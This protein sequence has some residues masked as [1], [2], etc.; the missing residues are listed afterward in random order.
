MNLIEKFDSVKITANT[1]LDTA[2][3][4]FCLAHQNAYEAAKEA[5]LE[6]D[7]FWNDILAVQRTHLSSTSTSPFSYLTSK[8]CLKISSDV[9]QKELRATH[10]TFIENLVNYFNSNYHIC[11]SAQKIKENLLP[12][13]PENSS[14]HDETLHAYHREL[15]NCS[16]T[17][18]QILEQI[19][20]QL[21]GR[22]FPQ[23][24]FYQL[25]NNCH[26]AAWN[27]YRKCANYERKKSVIQFTH[28]ACSYKSWPFEGKWE[29]NDSMKQ[30]LRG[31]I[32]YE[33]DS[34]TLI[35]REFSKLLGYGYHETNEIVFTACK[36]I[37]SMKAFKNGR[38]DLR[39]TEEGYATEFAETY[40]GT[41]C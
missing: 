15:Q 21:N 3:Q 35:P 16:L 8:G 10:S 36:K 25:K 17:S 31:I 2:E 20:L 34:F 28:Y 14:L 13:Q 4:D 41:I 26:A 5:L 24:A 27:V 32:H 7:Y 12:K 11:I 37:Q 1:Y 39:F 29:L 23:E 40:L 38:V 18:N 19:F 33:T 22:R 30:I 6:L 9:I